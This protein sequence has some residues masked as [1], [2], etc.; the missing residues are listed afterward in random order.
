MEDVMVAVP[1]E[2]DGITNRQ[3]A[4]P[5]YRGEYERVLE[6][7]ATYRDR[8]FPTSRE[9]D[10]A[11]QEG[12]RLNLREQEGENFLQGYG[13]A[14]MEEPTGLSFYR[15]DREGNPVEPV[16]YGDSHYDLRLGVVSQQHPFMTSGE[17]E[18]LRQRVAN[19]DLADVQPRSGTVGSIANLQQANDQAKGA[20][21]ILE[22][23]VG[24]A[25]AGYALSNDPWGGHYHN[26]DA[27][28]T[29]PDEMING[30]AMLK[31]DYFYRFGAAPTRAAIQS[32][33]EDEDFEGFG[34]E[35]QRM[36]RALE[37]SLEME[38]SD[39]NA[40]GETLFDRAMK[41]MPA[42]VSNEQNTTPI[43]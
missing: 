17:L 21:S 42:V 32:I 36:L 5:Y 4:E 30:L 22:H 16:A 27:H 43:S 15:L 1:F 24:H 20:I 38:G 9:P 14:A 13:R 19:R 37:E 11:F 28:M 23:E 40:E 6:E 39:Q 41:L 26:E 18:A 12:P 31:R 33:L 34:I 25:S 35:S 29:R 8:V 10:F 7:A 3:I 2:G